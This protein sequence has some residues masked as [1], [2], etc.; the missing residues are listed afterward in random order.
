MA[1]GIVYI[2]I[3]R[4]TGHKYIGQTLLPQ[5]KIWQHHIQS[6]MRMSQESL[7]K[8]MRKDGNHNFMIRELDSCDESNLDE[9]EQY[10][11]DQ[12]QPEYNNNIEVEE[13]IEKKEPLIIKKKKYGFQIAKNRGSGI[14]S[15]IGMLGINIETGEERT[16]ES[17][18]SASEDVTGDPKYAHNILNA[19]DK[20][21]KAYGYRWR[22]IGDKTNKRKVYG[23]HKVTWERT[24]IYDSIRDAIRK[25][26]GTST[27]TGLSKSLKNPHKYTWKGYYWFYL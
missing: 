1:Q 24:P 20:G 12:Y 2:I 25:H 17:A 6:A 5:N 4:N 21:W 7:H 27:G 18:S 22:R 9:R 11:I 10:W 3:N 16:W 13:I 19:A 26:V 14:T 15:R 8:G 23:V